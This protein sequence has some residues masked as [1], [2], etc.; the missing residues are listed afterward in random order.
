VLFL[1][2]LNFLMVATDTVLI[3]RNRALDRKRAAGE[4]V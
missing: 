2:I 4:K 3:Y 1:Y